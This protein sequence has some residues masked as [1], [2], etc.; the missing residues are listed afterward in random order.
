M[1]HERQIAI[2]LMPLQQKQNT[3]LFDS[4]LTYKQGTDMVKSSGGCPNLMTIIKIIK[5]LGNN[6]IEISMI[7][8]VNY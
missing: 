2:N 1:R 3:F 6:F 4:V 5:S 8:L 7:G